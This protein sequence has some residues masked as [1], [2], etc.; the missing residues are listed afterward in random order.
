ME[1][2]RPRFEGE[3]YRDVIEYTLILSHTIDM[4]NVDK[5]TLRKWREKHVQRD[6][7]E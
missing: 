7:D 3:T 4:C 1:C 6:I 5:E 2:S